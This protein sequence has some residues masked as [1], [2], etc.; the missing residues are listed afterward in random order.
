MNICDVLQKN[1][2]FRQKMLAEAT[3][4]SSRVMEP[5]KSVKTERK[6]SQLLKKWLELIEKA[7]NDSAM[8]KAPFSLFPQKST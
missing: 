7:L 4:R 2:K 5:P 3:G 8:S 1:L 6:L